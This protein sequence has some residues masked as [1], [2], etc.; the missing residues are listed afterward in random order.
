MKDGA[1]MIVYI[2][3]P[4]S[5]HEDYNRPAFNDAARRLAEAGHVPINPAVL[6]TELSD[7][8][9]MPICT[10]MI[11]GAD[12]IYLL[13]GWER[14]GGAMAEFAYARRQ[15][16]RIYTQAQLLGS[17]AALPQQNRDIR[18]A[19]MDT[20]SNSSLPEEIEGIDPAT[21][22]KIAE[23]FGQSVRIATPQPRQKRKKYGH[24]R[25]IIDVFLEMGIHSVF[26][27]AP[28][29]FGRDK[30]TLYNTMRMAIDR[31]YQ[32]APVQVVMRSGEAGVWLVRT[33]A[34]PNK[35]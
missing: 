2:A 3:G 32:D 30:A 25:R 5:G 31:N 33:D 21:K 18:E 8:A 7:S 1:D 22:Q 16:K 4:M 23:M 34:D 27:N 14:S 26:F 20:N 10:S 15:G 9:Y 17:R 28:D 19:F 29:V 13:D 6:P 12:A 24:T 35:F 11:D